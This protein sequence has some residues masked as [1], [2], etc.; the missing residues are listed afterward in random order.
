MKYVG[1]CGF[2][3]AGKT[4][5]ASR[6]REL[7][8]WLI[9]DKR[10]VLHQLFNAGWLRQS[11]DEVWEAWYRS[12]YARFDSGQVMLKVLEHARIVAP[13]TIIDSIHTPDEWKVVCAHAPASILVGVWAPELIRAVRRE[14]PAEMDARRARFW[15]H[16]DVPL[17]SSVEWAFTGLHSKELLN[18]LCREFITYV[19][20]S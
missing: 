1:L 9:L 6:L 15:Y 8:G 11:K 17:I 19:S 7:A 4:Y 12:V 18:Q 5:L 3:G 10:A 13:I 14:E 2:H 20:K 16:G